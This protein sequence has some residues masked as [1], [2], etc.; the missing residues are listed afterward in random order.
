MQTVT[1]ATI[2]AYQLPIRL[3]PDVVQFRSLEHKKVAIDSLKCAAGARA[4]GS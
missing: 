2:S 1:L 4:T 3:S